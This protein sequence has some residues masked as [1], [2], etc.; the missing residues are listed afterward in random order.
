ME[1]LNRNDSIRYYS[2]K[3]LRDEWI[4]I[5]SQHESI[6]VRYEEVKTIKD[7]NKILSNNSDV[8]ILLISAHGTY[9]NNFA[10]L[11]IGDE[12]LVHEGQIE[13]II[14]SIVLLSACHVSPRGKGVIS[15][16]D[17]LIAKGACVVLGTYIPIQ[18][19]RNAL[20]MKRF[21]L[22]I[23]YTQKGENEFKNLG[24]LWSFVVTSNALAEI[25]HSNLFVQRWIEEENKKG[26]SIEKEF[27]LRSRMRLKNTNIYEDTLKVLCEIATD[28]R[29]KNNLTQLAKSENY[30]PESLFYCMY[31]FPEN[32]IFSDC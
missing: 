17:S 2:D 13:S 19:D 18:V 11:C 15:I 24:E 8:D 9:N 28:Q 14:P 20:L 7:F 26:I 29:I 16:V 1:C 12:V 21:L 31:G 27:K 32:I 30:F 23:I 22:N 10:G 6:E 4:K 3:Y 25:V 5:G